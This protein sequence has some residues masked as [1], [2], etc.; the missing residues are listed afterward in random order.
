MTFK[1]KKKKILREKI[2][3]LSWILENLVK[4]ELEFLIALSFD[5]KQFLSTW[6]SCFL[7]HCSY[8]GGKNVYEGGSARAFEVSCPKE[9]K[10][11]AI[12]MSRYMFPVNFQESK[13]RYNKFNS[14]VSVAKENFTTKILGKKKRI[15]S[16]RKYLLLN[17]L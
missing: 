7:K 12:Y 8:Y 2:L 9:W 5:S 10:K 13:S 11:V 6:C 17:I 14:I 3:V 15:I 16:L 4:K 1:L